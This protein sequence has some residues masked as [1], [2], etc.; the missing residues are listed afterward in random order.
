[1]AAV[2]GAQSTA[3][4]TPATLSYTSGVGTRRGRAGV[5]GAA[6]AFVSTT[7]GLGPV[8]ARLGG[9]ALLRGRL[10]H[11]HLPAGRRRRRGEH[12]LLQVDAGLDGRDVPDH[13]AGVG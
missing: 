6:P 5:A 8:E 7:S 2:L 9:A 3:R 4:Q 10:A 11:D 1:M 13:L 12:G